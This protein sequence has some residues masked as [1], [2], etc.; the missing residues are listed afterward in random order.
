MAGLIQIGNQ[1]MTTTPS[2]VLSAAIQMAIRQIEFPTVD[3]SGVLASTVEFVD[4]VSH[5]DLGQ[6]TSTRL[7]I[8]LEND[9]PILHGNA[10]TIESLRGTQ[11]FATDPAPV[12]EPATLALLCAA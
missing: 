3:Y 4:P 7:M 8:V 1:S 11:S 10:E 12:L 9:A 5:A 6:L 2:S